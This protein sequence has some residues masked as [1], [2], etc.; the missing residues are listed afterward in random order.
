ME[1]GDRWIE[2]GS[3]LVEPGLDGFLVRRS[4]YGRRDLRRRRRRRLSLVGWV[5]PGQT[6]FASP[7]QPM[8]REARGIR[9]QKALPIRD[10]W[11]TEYAIVYLRRLRYTVS[12]VEFKNREAVHET[13]YFAGQFDPRGCAGLTEA[14]A[15]ESGVGDGALLRALEPLEAIEL[16]ERS[17]AATRLIDLASGHRRLT[18]SHARDL[19]EDGLNL[20]PTGPLWL[21]A[22]AQSTGS[23]GKSARIGRRSKFAILQA[24]AS[25][26]E[27]SKE[28]T[29]VVPLEKND[30]SASVGECWFSARHYVARSDGA[31][32][33]LERSGSGPAHRQAT[34]HR[35][36]R[37]RRSRRTW[38]RTPCGP[39]ISDG[40][41]PILGESSWSQQ[42]HV[43]AVRRKF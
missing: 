15:R 9:D 24:R 13:R 31:H 23:V 1:E 17:R 37:P 39:G 4:E 16:M 10:L 33:R 43:R 25:V 18:G 27:W 40:F 11:I 8:S 32:G 26:R 21:A 30:G 6:Q 28:I 14:E 19:R 34:Q 5:D 22:T 29:G 12:V 41:L 36:R 35:R 2:R 20:C 38:G 3:Q 7:A 42:F